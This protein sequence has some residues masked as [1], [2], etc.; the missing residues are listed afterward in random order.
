MNVRTF[1]IRT[2]PS[3]IN[4]I[5]FF[6]QQQKSSFWARDF[7]HSHNVVSTPL[8]T[9]QFNESSTW[10]TATQNYFVGVRL[11]RR[12]PLVSAAPDLPSPLKLTQE[13]SCTKVIYI[14]HLSVDSDNNFGS[15]FNSKAIKSKSGVRL[16][17]ALWVISEKLNELTG[18]LFLT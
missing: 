16:P 13:V 15:I 7:W 11:L 6:Q 2:T 18:Y 4:G 9:D 12:E 17:N 8:A 10:L 5:S 14:P 3:I 1:R